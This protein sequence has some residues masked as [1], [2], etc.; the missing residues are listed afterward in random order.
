M[1]FLQIVKIHAPEKK[2]WLGGFGPAWAG[3]INN[4]SDTFAA[5]FL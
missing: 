4:L 2:V 3:G 5:G 1:C